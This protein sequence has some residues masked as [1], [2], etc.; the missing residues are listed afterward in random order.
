M[1][2]MPTWLPVVC[3]VALIGC[4]E[5]AMQSIVRS[6]ESLLFTNTWDLRRIVAD[7]RDATVVTSVRPNS[8]QLHLVQGPSGDLA[9]V[10][11]AGSAYPGSVTVS[12]LSGSRVTPI[13]T[14]TGGI[15]TALGANVLYV[16][17]STQNAIL[18]FSWPDGKPSGTYAV[19]DPQTKIAADRDT[20]YFSEGGTIFRVARSGGERE[21]LAHFDGDVFRLVATERSVLAVIATPAASRARGREYTGYAA[22][23]LRDSHVTEVLRD[24]RLMNVAADGDMLY[25]ALTLCGNSEIMA[26]DGSRN[27]TARTRDVIQPFSLTVVPDGV[28]ASSG[29]CTDRG[30]GYLR[31]YDRKL[32]TTSTYDA[33]V[34]SPTSVTLEAT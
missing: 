15:S 5:N 33:G 32:H 17:A 26:L 16:S 29:L 13:V 2:R 23:E 11:K 22:Y 8:G 30:G 20:L 9:L 7:G 25:V 21:A 3:A 34:D 10:E 24:V 18:A 4:T 31:R 6:G 1:I 14:V 19:N 27:V 28:I 12:A